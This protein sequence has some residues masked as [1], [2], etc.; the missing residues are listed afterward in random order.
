MRQTMI[1]LLLLGVV[2]P[3]LGD[4]AFNPEAQAKAVAP[5]VDD[6]T[7]AVAHLDVDRL[8]PQVLAKWL[9]K[10][11]N[12]APDSV[13]EEV[14]SL[15]ALRKQFLDAGG[16]HVYVVL[17]LSDIPQSFLLV[18]PL[19]RQLDDTSPM[20]HVLQR[21]LG[22]KSSQDAAVMLAAPKEETLKRIGKERPAARPELAKAFATAGAGVAQVL[23]VPPTDLRR[24]IE[25]ALPKLPAELGGGASRTVTRGLSW[26][27][28]TIAAT[29][30]LEARLVIQAKDA[31]AATALR[32][33]LERLVAE[34]GK[35]PELQ[36][37][38]PR[39]EEAAR[40]LKPEITD[41]HRLRITL[42]EDQEPIVTLLRDVNDIASSAA[43]RAQSSNHLKQLGLAFH[44]Y[45]D[46]YRSFPPSAHFSKDG[47]PLLSWRV[48]ILPFVGEEKLYKEFHLDEPWD[49]EHNRK[50]IA[51]MPRVFRIPGTKAPEGRTGYLAVIGKDTMFTGEPKGVTMKEVTDGTSNTIFLVEA[52][53]DHAVEW[54]R[55]SDLKFDEKAPTTGFRIEGKGGFL[56]GFADGSVQ[57]ISKTVPPKTVKALLTRNGGEV[58][59]RP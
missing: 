50:L 40:L 9:A 7:I 16:R 24:A 26:A 29:P 11:T 31:D 18:A 25:E 33:L 54:T 59:E 56:A 55:P 19:T 21:G 15:A 6:Q 3:A 12:E 20:H 51:R 4:E 45:H 58:V 44:N 38:Y 36:R 10:L 2:T 57:F 39:F 47:K 22:L 37:R 32:G 27:T 17:R 41:D 1:L 53:D 43:Q 30:I 23:V 34:A 5:Y 49:S 46:V 8:D 48:L 28:L 35:S 52:N 13:A 42:K 14:K